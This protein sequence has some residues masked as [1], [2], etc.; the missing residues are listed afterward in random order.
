MST[1]EI[2]IFHCSPVEIDRIDPH[3]PF[4]EFEGTL[5]FALEPYSLGSYK[6]MYTVTMHDEQAV[7]VSDLEPLK[8]DIDDVIHHLR[9]YISTEDIE[10]S[11]DC[12]LELITKDDTYAVLEEHF[13]DVDMEEAAQLGWWMQ[14]KQARIARR[15]GFVAAQGEDEQGVV[16]MIDMVEREYILGTPERIL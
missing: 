7:H 13:S 10:C 6:Y 4:G 3:T 2:T 11:Y 9:A 5:F 14:G 12:A 16:Y 8:S 15:M 1:N